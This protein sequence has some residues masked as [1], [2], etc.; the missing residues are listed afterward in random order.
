MDG[1]KRQ[2]G[3]INA[4]HFLD[5]YVL[6]I[7]PTVVIG[8]EAKLG[9][10]YAELIV[11]STACFVAFGLFSL[12][13][14][15]LGDHWSR[16]KLIAIFFF[17]CSLSLVAA[18]LAPNMIW[19]AVALFS[20]GIFAAIY[21]PIGIPKLISHARDRGRDLAKNG[22]FGNL[23]VA[24]AP[25]AT[26]AIAVAFGWR[27]AFAVPAIACAI[28][29]LAYLWMTTEEGDKAADRART[30]EVPLIY[31]V[32]VAMLVAFAFVSFSAGLIFNIITVAIPKIVDERL[33]QDVPLVLIG[34]VATMVLL[35]GGIA[36]LTVGRLVSKYPPHLLFVAIGLIQ[37]VGVLWSM[38]A[39]GFALLVALAF[40]IAGIYAQV[41][42]ADVV[43]A[44]YTADAWRGRIY[45]LRFF[46]AFISSG[47]AIGLIAAL[48]GRGGF[49]LVLGVTAICAIVF[50][51]GA[52]AIASL[53]GRVEAGVRRVQPAE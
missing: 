45:S 12:P 14:G 27:A 5:H 31:A 22:V 48:H 7:F 2:I 36:Q 8:L 25:G 44:R 40:A 33:A 15:W 26:A 42:V 49:F 13:W 21:H 10:S 29:G 53:A 9:R 1:S 19:L 23:G 34:S 18:A 24:C 28:A 37:L 41:T 52:I 43:I 50:L 51:L 3:F 38:Y 35:V 20:L 16:R 46:L 17:G 6:L 47:A 30:A 39:G 11:L 32:A 4:A